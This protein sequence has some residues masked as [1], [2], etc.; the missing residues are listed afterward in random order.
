MSMYINN[1][2]AIFLTLLYGKVINTD[3]GDMF[4]INTNISFFKRLQMGLL[5][6]VT[7]LLLRNLESATDYNYGKDV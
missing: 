7:V 3:I 1:D 2:S 4:I 5:P 6:T